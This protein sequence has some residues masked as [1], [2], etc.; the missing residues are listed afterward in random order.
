M[1]EKKNYKHAE[2]FNLMT[3]T[4]RDES[5]G[6]EEVIWNSRDGVTP[7]FVGCI[8]CKGS[9]AR[10]TGRDIYAPDHKPKSG[11]RIFYDQKGEPSIK[12]TP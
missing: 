5:C 9:L 7:M 11:E 4:C 1:S 2:A 6:K 8:F 10:H 12:E 3:Y